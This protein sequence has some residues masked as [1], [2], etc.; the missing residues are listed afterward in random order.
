MGSH[1]NHSALTKRQWGNALGF[2]R[3]GKAL[4]G[5]DIAGAP[6]SRPFRACPVGHR[7]PRALPWAGLSWAF[8]PPGIL[9]GE[10][11]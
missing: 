2:C 4:K 6:M 1:C 10:L 8:G 7:F 3:S 5:R 11:V 9:N